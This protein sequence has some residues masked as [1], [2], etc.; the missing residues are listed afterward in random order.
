MATRPSDTVRAA[1]YDQNRAHMWDVVRM[2]Q[3]HDCDRV[4]RCIGEDVWTYLRTQTEAQIGSLMMSLLLELAGRPTPDNGD[5][6]C[7]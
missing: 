3:E 7:A 1:V 6:R 2:V 4:P 5:P